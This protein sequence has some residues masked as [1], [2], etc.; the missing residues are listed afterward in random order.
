MILKAH[1]RFELRQGTVFVTAS[2]FGAN[3][4]KELVAK[5]KAAPLTIYDPETAE[6]SNYQVLGVENDLRLGAY[7]DGELMCVLVRPASIFAQENLKSN[8]AA[9]I[10]HT[11]AQAMY[12]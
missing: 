7:R 5:L 8:V 12:E 1:K 10:Q 11:T 2:P 4:F 6:A 9:S 3:S